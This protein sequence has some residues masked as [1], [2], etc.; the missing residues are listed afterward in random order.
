MSR[1]GHPSHLPPR[2][3]RLLGYLLPAMQITRCRQ[4]YVKALCPYITGGVRPSDGRRFESVSA[5]RSLQK[6]LDEADGRWLESTLVL[7]FLQKLLDEADGRWLESTL[8]FRFLQ[9]LLDEA[10]GRRFESVSAF[11]SLQKLLDRRTDV[12]SSPL[13]FSVVFKSCGLLTLSYDFAPFR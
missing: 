10:D 6:L 7:R 11:C 2:G 1:A 13:W 4:L 8:V 3:R 12:G 9:K 5:F